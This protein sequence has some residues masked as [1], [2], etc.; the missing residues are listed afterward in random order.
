MEDY[1]FVYTFEVVSDNQVRVDP[2]TLVVMMT[3]WWLAIV[4]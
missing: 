3:V 2:T 4:F 1:G